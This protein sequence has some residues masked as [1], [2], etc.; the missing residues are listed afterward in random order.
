MIIY[1]KTEN[2]RLYHGDNLILLE[3]MPDAKVN[4][5]YCDVLYNTKSKFNDYEDDLGTPKEAVEW[6][7]P[8]FEHMKR[9]LA[10]NGSIYIHC[11]WHL[12]SYLRVLLDEIFGYES[13]RNEIAR[14]CTNA[15]NNSS[16]WGRVYDNILFYVKNPNDFVWNEM[17]EPKTES[18]L[19]TQYNKEAKDGRRYTT[20][21]LNAKG[22]TMNGETGKDWNSKSHGLVKLTAGRHWATSHSVM[23]EMDA[24]GLI[25][26]SKNGNP[27]KILYADEYADKHIQNIWDV[28][29]IGGDSEFKDVYDTQKPIELLDRIIR[30]SSNEG[31]IVADFFMGSCVSGYVSK[32]LNRFYIGCDINEKS[33]KLANDIF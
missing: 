18:E 8:R 2:C 5:I 19:L 6:Y 20:V 13:F 29:S 10:D 17:K 21:P 30:A 23:D 3:N 28:K 7:R 32:S 26:W 1:K 4:L 22:V 12:N 15:K 33:L 14:K 31:D 27:R 25:E 9:I 24:N 16:N 11:D